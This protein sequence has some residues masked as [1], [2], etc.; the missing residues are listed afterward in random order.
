MKT[1]SFIIGKDASLESTIETK[2]K[3]LAARGF[4]LNG[5]GS[6]CHLSRQDVCIGTW[7]N[8]GRLSVPSFLVRLAID[9]G[10]RHQ[11]YL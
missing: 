11:D 6:K 10:R 5:R 2:Q 4:Q 1:E 8:A 7:S 3:K 9:R